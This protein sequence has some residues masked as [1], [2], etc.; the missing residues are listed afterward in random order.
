MKTL[1]CFGDSN[2]HGSVPMRFVGDL[3]RY[4]PAVRWPG[5]A[6][7]ILGDDWQVIEEGHPGRTTVHDDPIEGLYKNGLPALSVAMESHR[8]IDVV[9]IMLG[10][11][12]LKL[13][14]SL[15][16]FDIALS[17]EKLVGV[18]R[19]SGGGPDTG[20][21]AIL[22]VAP[23]P[24]LEAG[25]LAPIFTGGAAKSAEFGAFYADAAKRQDV[26]FFDAGAIVQSS[27]VDGIHWEESAHQALGEAIAGKVLE[28]WGA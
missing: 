17:A 16:A 22:L 27:A 26:P 8:P 13:R 7:G 25:F 19:D 20:A 23:P 21:P 5:I 28:E 1:V 3:R 18:A 11:N 24:I 9:V 14:Y 6:A 15:S 4:P 12:D 2:T 10:T